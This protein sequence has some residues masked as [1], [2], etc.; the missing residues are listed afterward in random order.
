MAQ[1]CVL[2]ELLRARIAKRLRQQCSPRHVPAKMV[3]V[4]DLP[5]TRSGKQAELAVADVVHGR[6]VRNTE[7]LAN[8]ESLLLFEHL[9]EL[10]R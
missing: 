8:P 10:Q 4:D 7:A 5:R 2:D 3:A 1:G 9:E 6:P